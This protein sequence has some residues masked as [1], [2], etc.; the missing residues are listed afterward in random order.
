MGSHLLD[1]IHGHRTPP[2]SVTG[3]AATSNH[4]IPAIQQGPRAKDS[5]SSKFGRGTPSTPPSVPVPPGAHDAQMPRRLWLVQT[6]SRTWIS[7]SF[8]PPQTLSQVRD[9]H[10][11]ALEISQEEETSPHSEPVSS[12]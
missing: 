3:Q 4:A 6:G 5:S 11:D 9:W 2:P 1:L 10:P 8:T 7:A 12:T